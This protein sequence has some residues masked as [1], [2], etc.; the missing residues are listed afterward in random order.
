MLHEAQCTRRRWNRNIARHL[1][2]DLYSAPYHPAITKA[3]AAAAAVA[4][5]P[6][7]AYKPRKYSVF[8]SDAISGQR[9]VC[10]LKIVSTILNK[11]REEVRIFTTTT[12][13]PVA[14]TPS[15]KLKDNLSSRNSRNE[16][17]LSSAKK[18]GGC[19]VAPLRGKRRNQTHRLWLDRFENVS[20]FH[21]LILIWAIS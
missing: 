9:C 13:L 20:R 18:I 15:P 14:T 17:A 6:K 1:H 8:V 11:R 2:P 10:L 21:N 16:A 7:A 5:E 12:A 4:A 3:P 19:P